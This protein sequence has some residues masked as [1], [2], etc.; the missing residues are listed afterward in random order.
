M[1]LEKIYFEVE[2]QSES[3]GEKLLSLDYFCVNL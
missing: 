2:I 3:E 1:E